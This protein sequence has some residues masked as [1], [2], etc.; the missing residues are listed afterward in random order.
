[1]LTSF[2]VHRQCCKDMICE[3]NQCFFSCFFLKILLY[4]LS[5]SLS[6]PPSLPPSLSLSLY[7]YLSPPPPSVPLSLSLSLPPSLPPF[8]PSFYS[9]IDSLTH[10]MNLVNS[11]DRLVEAC[12]ATTMRMPRTVHLVKQL[13]RELNFSDAVKSLRK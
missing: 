9:E 13:R 1:M 11:V 12:E 10:A 4:F 8:P 7:L 3:T 5:L 6:L 2:C